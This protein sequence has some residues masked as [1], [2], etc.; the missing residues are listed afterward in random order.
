MMIQLTKDQF[1]LHQITSESLYRSLVKWASVQPEA[2]YAVEIET[3]HEFTYLQTLT[4]VNATRNALGSRPRRILLALPNSIASTIIWLSALSGGHQ[5]IP[6]SPDAAG[7]EKVLAMQRYK[8]EIAFVEDREQALEFGLPQEAIITRPDYE[9]LISQSPFFSALDS[10]HGQ[11]CLTTSG[12]TG[13]P[14]SIVLHERQ[15]VWT[16]FHVCSNHELHKNDRGLCVLPFSHVN[17]PVVSLCASLLAG[18]SVVIARRFSKRNFWSWIEQYRITWASIVPT[19]VAILLETAKPPFLPG[20]LRFVRTGSAP[21]PAIDLQAFEERFGIPVIETYGMSEAASQIV[22]NPLPPEAHK[23]GSAGKPVGVAL[24]ICAPRT[25]KEDATLHQVKPGETGEICISGPGVIDAYMNNTEQGAFQNGWFRTGDLGYLDEEGYLFIKGRL[26]EVIIRGGENIAPREIEEVLLS[27]P[28]VRE[29]VAVGRPDRIYGEQVV[30]Y[31]VTKAPWEP[32][33]DQELK[34]YA[35][36]RLSAYKVPI[37][38]IALE[39]LPKSATGKIERKLLQAR[40]RAR[41]HR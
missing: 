33:L 13:E 9:V 20:T 41:N 6:I 24:C 4:A 5:L 22:A 19:I 35:A 16:A 29:A 3:Q 37:D 34:V 7:K 8:P 25:D 27:H 36:L 11:V 26:R 32:E 2:I 17:A 31:I 30:A 21:L 40:E 15:I 14:K 10:L 23:P 1:T 18:S 28:L 38:F 12:T 39:S